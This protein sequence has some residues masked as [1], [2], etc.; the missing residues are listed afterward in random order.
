[1]D[2]PAASNGTNPFKDVAQGA[3]YYDA[4]VWA[5]EAEVTEGMTSDTFAPNL[6]CTRGQIV[7]FLY[8]VLG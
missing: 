2:A 8:R 6:V 1:M 7:T 5:V 4:V 3:F